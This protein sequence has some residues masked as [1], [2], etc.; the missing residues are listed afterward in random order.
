MKVGSTSLASTSVREKSKF[1]FDH[2]D[3]PL[4]PGK[5]KN[6]EKMQNLRFR[7]MNNRFILINVA[8]CIENFFFIEILLLKR[9][10]IFVMY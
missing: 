4:Q 3:T 6:R 2:P 10:R 8:M 7:L 5:I 9:L 1:F